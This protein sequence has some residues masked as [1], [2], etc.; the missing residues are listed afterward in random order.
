[1]SEGDTGSEGSYI[2]V[3]TIDAALKYNFKN[4]TVIELNP[5]SM[6]RLSRGVTS[7]HIHQKHVA[8]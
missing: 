5:G 3:E 6:R 2:P 1:M 7:Q 4:R 8:N